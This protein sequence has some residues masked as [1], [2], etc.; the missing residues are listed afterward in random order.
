MSASQVL[1]TLRAAL[2]DEATG[3]AAKAEALK[4]ADGSLNRV[5]TDYQW[6]RWSLTDRM[7]TTGQPNVAVSVRRVLTEQR[8]ATFP[9]RDGIWSIEI[10]FE[11]F[12]GDDQALIED[13]VTTAATA[14]LQVLD[15]L[16]EYSDANAGT[17]LE[18]NAAEG[19]PSIDI[20]FGDFAGPVASFGFLCRFTVLE[21]STT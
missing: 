21:R 2:E 16:R 10:A 14:L 19:Q 17:V 1:T 15:G 20:Q 9:S 12:A 8:L 5:R 4:G 7:Q 3:M 6:V 18:I 11:C 13:S